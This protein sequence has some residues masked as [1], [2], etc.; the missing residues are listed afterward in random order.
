MFNQLKEDLREHS[1]FNDKRLS[2]R[3][4]TIIESI[5]ETYGSSLPRAGGNHGQ[6]QALYRF[7]NNEKVTSQALYQSDASR[8]KE[9]VSGLSG[10]TFISV[11]DKTELD[12]ST[13]KSRH[14]LDCLDDVKRHGLYT[15]SQMLMDNAGCPWGLIRQTHFNR[16]AS[17]VGNARKMSSKERDSKPIEEKES[18]HWLKDL[19]ALHTLFGQMP[20]HRFIHIIDA[21]G[22]I[23]ELFAARRFD[24]IHFLTRVKHDR[25]LVDNELKLKAAV[26]Q[27]PCQ[28]CRIL[29]VKDDKTGKK[30]LARLEIRYISLT[31]DVSQNL[32]K[33]QKDKNY[34]PLKVQVVEAKE[35]ID[36]TEPHDFDP[37]HWLLITS[38]PIDD[39][40]QALDIIHYYTLRWRIEDFHVVLKQGAHIEQL[41]FET[42]EALKNA[43]VVYSIVA[44]TVLRIRYLSKSQPQLPI[45][46]AGF[47]VQDVQI[48]VTYLTKVRKIKIAMPNQPTIAD[49]AQCLALL[50]TGNKNNTGIRALWTGFREFK[51]IKDTF[52][53]INS[54]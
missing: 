2:H 31:I 49:F 28:G 16:P 45:Q 5:G 25:S 40:E 37:L 21:E 43:I 12:Y 11:S 30:R 20:Q 46:E 24:H 6:T 26:A 50:A 14:V 9:Q 18:Y 13:A 27:S 54:T 7:M 33:Y 44:I 39:L 47:E 38:L 23:F 36:K 1:Y 42:Q 15:Q 41:Q 34:S 51:L 3:F 22:D 29:R 10:R 32:Q 52:S 8:L 53:L 17:E 4:G 48:L 35:I 19:A